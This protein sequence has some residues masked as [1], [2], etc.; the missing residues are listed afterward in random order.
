METL[1]DSDLKDTASTLPLFE[2]T[3]IEYTEDFNISALNP[4]SGDVFRFFIAERYIS[5]SYKAIEQGQCY[6]SIHYSP[7]S[8][9]AA[10]AFHSG[11]LFVNPRLKTVLPRRLCTIENLF[12]TMSCSEAEY[13]KVAI[14]IDLPIDLGIRG[15]LIQ[16]YIDSSPGF[17]PSLQRNGFTS[18]E[19]NH[20]ESFSMRITHSSLLTLYDPL[21][22][23]VHPGKFVRQIAQIAQVPILKFTVN[24]E[25]GIK[26]TPEI[27][28]QIFSRLNVVQGMFQL[29]KLFFEADKFRYEIVHLEEFKFKVTRLLCESIFQDVVAEAEM[30]EF[31]VTQNA[32]RVLSYRFE[33]VDSIVLVRQNMRMSRS[34]SLS[35]LE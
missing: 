3:A 14:I 24:N 2:N 1:L 11:C 29:F 26:F 30:T 13:P 10:I 34:S 23:L 18:N 5:F 4:K 22:Q 31:Y 20:P 32:I 35:K 16:L 12:E 17:F 7:Q 6:G 21:P 33:S 28:V 8:D 15:V 27:F 9:I 19:W 25:I